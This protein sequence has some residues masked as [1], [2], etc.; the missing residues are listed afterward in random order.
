MNQFKLSVFAVTGFALSMAACAPAFKGEG[1]LKPNL[2]KQEK[3]RLQQLEKSTS[4]ASFVNKVTRNEKGEV[5]LELTNVADLSEE[6]R[7]VTLKLSTP[8]FKDDVVLQSSSR[9]YIIEASCIVSDCLA[10]AIVT[11]VEQQLEMDLQGGGNSKPLTQQSNLEGPAT[12][13]DDQL[14]LD[15]EAQANVKLVEESKQDVL[16]TQANSQAQSEKKVNL[17]GVDGT[18]VV[19]LGV[20]FDAKGEGKKFVQ[21]PLPPEN[22]GNENMTAIYQE[23]QIQLSLKMVE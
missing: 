20:T 13:S 5:T 6:Q 1:T 11:R 23:Y 19:G 16:E 8:D 4:A 7:K 17:P 3:A 10:V 9:N 21:M 12:E 14:D 15:L 18:L 22:T 2:Q